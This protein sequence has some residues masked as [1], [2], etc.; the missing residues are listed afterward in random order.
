[1]CR[2]SQLSKKIIFKCAFQNT[3]YPASTISQKSTLWNGVIFR[4]VF[5]AICT[6]IFGGLF[7]KNEDLI[8][9]ISLNL[10]PKYNWLQITL[11]PNESS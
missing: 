9:F 8:Y 5:R 4:M 10:T 3:V 6:E 2:Y 1:M 11:I 7:F